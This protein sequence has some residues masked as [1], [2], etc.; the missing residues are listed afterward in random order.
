MMV[1][2]KHERRL[3][4]VC[5]YDYFY[6]NTSFPGNFFRLSRSLFPC[7]GAIHFLKCGLD[8]EV[9]LSA[10][11]LA[12]SKSRAHHLASPTTGESNAGKSSSGLQPS[13]ICKNRPLRTIVVGVLQ[14]FFGCLSRIRTCTNP[15]EGVSIRVK[16]PT[17]GC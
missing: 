17:G 3:H 14:V 15:V 11:I 7:E 9:N 10:I 8:R 6:P 12:H 13:S 5:R 2:D 4:N 1:D 16:R